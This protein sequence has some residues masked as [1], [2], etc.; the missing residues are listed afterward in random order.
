ML[1][2]HS[3]RPE[4]ASRKPPPGGGAGARSERGRGSGE[5]RR[6]KS[7]APPT[8]AKRTVPG[9]QA[10]GAFQQLVQQ[11]PDVSLRHIYPLERKIARSICDP[12]EAVA[13]VAR[14]S[15]RVALR[16]VQRREKQ[17]QRNFSFEDSEGIR[18]VTSGNPPLSHFIIP[19]NP[20]YL[21][22]DRPNQLSLLPLGTVPGF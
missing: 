22:E 2:K 20:W 14:A 7:R 5:G 1:A 16:T 3:P 10:R 4:K 17:F 19:H 18:L 9:P 21:E 6:D 8:S 15:S 12:T 11:G 13:Q